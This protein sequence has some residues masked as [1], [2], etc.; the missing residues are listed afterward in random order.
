MKKG[1]V[2]RPFAV[3]AA[4]MRPQLNTLTYGSMKFNKSNKII[5]KIVLTYCF[6]DFAFRGGRCSTVVTHFYG[7]CFTAYIKQKPGLRY[8]ISAFVM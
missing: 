2:M 7:H 8:E 3:L 4:R 1:R 5:V 6:R